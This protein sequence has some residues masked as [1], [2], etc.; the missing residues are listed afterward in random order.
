[1]PRG[2]GLSQR[3]VT[4]Q[5]A[6]NGVN[7]KTFGAMGDGDTHDSKS[8]QSALDYLESKGGGKLLV[9]SGLYILEKTVLIPSNCHVE[10]QGKSTK[11]RGFRPQGVQGL[12]LIANKGIATAS[13]YNGASDF[14]VTNLSIDSPDTNGIVLIHAKN[15]YFSNIYGENTFHHIFDITGSKNIIIENMY[16]T[17]HSGTSPFQI[18]GYQPSGDRFIFNNNIW[19]GEK[20]IQPYHDKTENDGIYLTNSIIQTTNKTDMAIHFHRDGGKNIF[21]DNILISNAT[22]VVYR[23]VNCSRKNVKLSNIIATDCEQGIYFPE[24]SKQD[25]DISIENVTLNVTTGRI[26]ELNNVNNL[27]LENVI[28]TVS[29]IVHT[30]RFKLVNVKNAVVSV[31]IKDGLGS[32]SGLWVENCDSI[33]VK[34]LIVSDCSRLYRNDMS[35]NVMLN[36]FEEYKLGEKIDPLLLG[37]FNSQQPFYVEKSF[38]HDEL[39]VNRK[40]LFILPSNSYV[41][42]IWVSA[43]HKKMG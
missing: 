40:S 21:I 24:S 11:L 27:I 34:R 1:M 8:F 38:S 41:A 12:A 37:E 23:D 9:P 39:S 19:D 15:G 18:D 3:E 29:A 42:G 4:A 25:Y 14:S 2:C 30:I 43:T 20:I 36:L 33:H 28:G 16:V 10:G 13:G 35:T 17:G 31:E 32:G 26:V 7:V 22:Y 6:Q 5:L